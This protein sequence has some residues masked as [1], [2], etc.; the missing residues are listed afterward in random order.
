MIKNYLKI[1]WRNIW[2]NKS[3]SAINIGGLAVGMAVAILIG[4]WIYD[5]LN[6]N[7]YHKNYSQVAQVMQNQTFNGEVETWNS[8]ALQLAPELRN[9]YGEN[10][11][12]VI[13]ASFPEAAQINYDDKKLFKTGNYFEPGIIDMISLNML[14]G[15]K[16]SL[17]DPNS[18]ILSQSAANSIF[19]EGKKL[20]EILKIDNSEGLKVTGIYEDIPQNSSFSNLEFIVPFALIENNLPAWVGWGNSWFQTYV[21]I[22]DNA[23]MN[24]VSAKIKNAKSDNIGNSNGY[25]PEVF[26]QPMSNWRLYSEFENGELADGRIVYVWLFGIIGIFVLLLACINFMNLSTAR[27]EKRASEIGIR[28][29]VGSNRKQLIIQFFFESL[30]FVGLSFIISI[31]LVY[32]SLPFFNNLSE[33][34]TQI[35]WSNPTFWIILVGFSLLTGLISGSYPAIYL[36]S[37][38]PVKVLKGTFNVG[39][40]ASIPRKALVVVQFT[41]SITL[42]IG[43][44]VVF[45]QIQFAK[46]RPLGYD[47]DNLVIIPIKTNEIKK[48]YNSFRNTLINTRAVK[49]LAATDT[50]ITNT[51]VTNSGFFW[52]G[53]DSDMSE[54]F[55]TVRVSR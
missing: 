53:K 3:Y 19:G 41:V 37:F 36:S 5:E 8:Q 11:K 30:L 38:Q 28:K 48:K 16:S 23:D 52:E 6:F 22:G 43:T 47:N 12:H 35:L 51:Q 50:K 25:N 40:F 39:R 1:T 21:Q 49:E 31:L 32:L 34:N 44:L 17:K 46:N 2:N 26:L 10:F 29:A 45:E 14:Q 15:S 13:T 54:E 4:L 42:I 7:K 27:S 9:A 24:A 20:G 18:I 55:N 33:K